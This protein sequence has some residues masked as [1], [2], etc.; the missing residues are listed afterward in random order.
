MNN[1]P[2]F[3]TFIKYASANII[4]M[5]GLSCYILADTFFIAR[6]VGADG[7]AALNLAIPAYS[8]MNGL[9]LMTGMGGATRFSIAKGSGDRQ[10]R[11]SVFTQALFFLLAIAAVFFLAGLLAPYPLA[12]L[13]GA[14]GD[15]LL[16]AGQYLRIILLFAPAFMLNNLVNCFVR[17]DGCPRL[18]MSAM[19]LGSF[20]NI[21]LDYVFIF[22]M[23]LGMAGAALA[24]GVAPAVSLLVLS[25]HFIHKKNTFHFFPG[26]VRFKSILDICALGISSLISEVSSGVVMLVFNLL[27][28]KDSGNLG[29]A[30]YGVIANIALVL[31]SIFNGIS[32]GIQPILSSCFGKKDGTSIK[33]VLR[34]AFTTSALFA[35]FSYGVTFL[36]SGK[37]VDLFNKEHNPM[38]QEIAVKGMHIYFIAFIFMGINI[39][40]ASYFSAVD[41]PGQG[42]FISCLRGLILVL[43]LAF[44]L[45]FT[46]GITGIWLTVPAAEGLSAMIVF[47]L[48]IRQKNGPFP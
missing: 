4:G 5:V 8:F 17:N 24:T 6:G 41:K 18:S 20:S 31:V 35:I 34:Y 25:R 22:P 26:R 7:L 30:A 32:Q 38:L 14:Q 1:R 37:I 16:L 3:H 11:E 33:C 2:V 39:I 10:A 12:A 13:L 29:V 21:V 43:P 27:I 47:F 23:G 28:L 15:I 45:S 42:F 46:L 44:L 19:L 48:L 40:S 9:G 36:F